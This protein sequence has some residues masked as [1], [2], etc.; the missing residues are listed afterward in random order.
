MRSLSF[1]F[2]LGIICC[3]YALSQSKQEN[4]NRGPLN[5]FS[6]QSLQKSNQNRNP[7]FIE[8]DLGLQRP[9]DLKDKG[10]G[11]HIGF[12]SKLYRSN[13]AASASSGTGRVSGG[14]FENSLNNLFVLGAYDFEGTSFSPL[15]S[16]G[17]SKFSHF[18]DDD[19]DLLDFDTLQLGPNAFFQTSQGWTFRG[20][21]G[22]ML[23]F[24]PNDGMENTYRQFTPTI[25]VG[26]GFS[27]AQA[28]S[29]LEMSI[30]YH[31]T[32][33]NQVIDD[34]LDRFETGLLWTINFPINHFEIS[35]YLRLAYANYSNQNRDDLIGSLGME[36]AYNFTSWFSANLFSGLSFRTSSEDMYD[37]GRFDVGGGLR[38]QAKF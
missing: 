19:I 38:L 34:L 33:S 1:I 14:I 28:S 2:S 13:N 8:S 37:F 15:F 16:I 18:G 29:S 32:N 7:E 11:Y 5:D 31:F 20:G 22:V 10:F 4:F 12:S 3:S 27:I 23:D 24:A 21:L 17:Y 26:K 30:S 9:V 6:N 35:P 25:A 36:L